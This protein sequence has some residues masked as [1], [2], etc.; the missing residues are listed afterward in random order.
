MRSLPDWYERRR[1]KA[2]ELYGAG[3]PAK[4]GPDLDLGSYELCDEGLGPLKGLEQLSE[5]ELRALREVGLR[6]DGFYR[7]GTY[8][9]YDGSVAYLKLAREVAPE[10]LVV[11]DLI[12]AVR[13]YPWLRRYWFRACSLNLDKYTAFVGAHETA[14]AFIWCREGVHV[15]YPIQACLFLGSKGAV[16][17]PH[18]IIVLEPGSSLHVITGCVVSR[19]CSRAAHVACTEI[20]V[21]EGAELT[22][23]MIHSWRPDTHVRPRMGALVE[24]GGKLMVNYV[25]LSPVRSIQL[26]PTAVLLGRGARVGFRNLILALGRSIVDVGSAVIFNAEGSRG[27]IMSR[28]LVK[29]QADVRLRGKLW[30]R[31]PG[32][33][34]HLECRALI[35]SDWA[36]AQAYPNLRSDVEDAELTHE[37]AI[38]RIAEEELFY[39]MSRG[40]DRDEAVAL[41][42]KGF[43]DTDI[44]GLPPGLLKEIKGI[45][46]AT[47][48]HVL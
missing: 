42:S 18:N 33:R 27:E 8:L 44:P 30:G 5:E 23:T 15:E 16:Q 21:G 26:Y 40:L 35:L 31:K 29:D 32:V 48:E 1:R 36:V 13:K 7:S 45:V 43:L 25:L 37:A 12:T 47:V 24:G 17:V 46:E 22:W 28:A 10:G 38:G 6:D 34:G 9:Q 19:A 14:G 3:R 4:Y 20:Y 2:L 39:L 11:E 41:V